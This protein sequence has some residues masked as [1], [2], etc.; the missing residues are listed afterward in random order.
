MLARVAVLGQAP[1]RD[2][3]LR[4]EI[5]KAAIVEDG[6]LGKLPENLTEEEMY[7][8]L[9]CLYYRVLHLLMRLT[10][11]FLSG[12]WIRDCHSHC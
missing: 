9:P 6:S 12:R 7:D 1:I 8:R 10:L 5:L 4:A 11:S 2:L 3:R